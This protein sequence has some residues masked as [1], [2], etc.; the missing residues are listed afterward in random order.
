MYNRRVETMLSSKRGSRA[1][2]WAAM[3]LVLTVFAGAATAMPVRH[4]DVNDD[5]RGLIGRCML[6]GHAGRSDL[7]GSDA[8]QAC[9]PDFNHD[10]AVNFID[11][12]ML[13]ERF[14][15]NDLDVPPQG[16]D[17]IDFSDLA[18]LAPGGVRPPGGLRL[19]PRDGGGIAVAA[20]ATS[21]LLLA[22]LLG[23][24]ALRRLRG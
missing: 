22:G 6:F 18:F 23:W 1:A 17:M 14:Y 9:D 11:L 20:P 21:A 4:Q 7:D 19:T 16:G 8:R 10:G 3:T 24:R 13:R 15:T 2:T 5:S 12:A